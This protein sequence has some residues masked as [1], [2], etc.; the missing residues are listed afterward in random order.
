M[1]R[2]APALVLLAAVLAWWGAST[3]VSP[4]LLPSPVDVADAAWAER[5]RLA[6]ATW[7]TTRSSLLGLALASLLGLGGAVAFLRVRWLEAGFYPLALLLQTVPIIAIA[8]LLVVW[9][10]YGSPVAVTTAAIVCFFPILTAAN[11]GLRSAD[12]AEVELLRLYGASWLQELRLLRWWSGL[13][14]LFTGYRTAVGLSVIGAI[15]GEFVGSNGQPPCLGNLVL[16]SAGAADT[17]L[18][19]AAIGAST[20]VALVLF[21]AVRLLERASIGRWH[22]G[23]RT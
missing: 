22:A 14:F 12:P 1:K 11:L 7:V 5:E 4:I 18:T 23:S 13:P 21:G 16:R 2:F 6:Q 20:G 10:G 3:Q 19:F 8:P 9:L 15:V 17:A